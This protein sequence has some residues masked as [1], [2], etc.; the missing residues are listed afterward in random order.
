[1]T[2]KR[3]PA[4]FRGL[5]LMI[6]ILLLLLFAV[7]FLLAVYYRS[8]F[9]LNTWINGIYCTGKT[10]GQVNEE[11]IAQT[12]PPVV[13][14]STNS[15]RDGMYDNVID[16]GEMGYRCD[17]LSAL[18]DYMEKQNPYLWVDNITFHRDHRIEPEIS[19]DESALRAA[20]GRTC[21]QRYSEMRSGD[22]FLEITEKTGW[23]RYDGLTH[24]FDMEKA[25]E[26]VKAAIA[27]GRS[28]INIDELDC[29]YDIPFTDTQEQTRRMYEKLRAFLDCD[30]R[31]D[32]G[33]SFES[34]NEVQLSFFLQYSYREDLKMDYPVLDQNGQFVLKQEEV[35]A[36]VAGLAEKYDT[37]GKDREFQSTRGD[38]VTVPG[39]GTYGTTLDQH[40]E[41]EY[42][43]EH[44]LSG[45]LHDGRASDRIPEYQRQGA[46]RGKDDIGGTYI[47]VDMTRQHL[48]YY[49]DRELQFETDVVTGNTGRRMGTPEGVNYVY[50][51]QRNRTLRGP[52]YATPVKYWMPVKGNVGIHDAGWRTDFGGE[53]YKKNG[54]HG[55]INV[56]R[57]VMGELYDQV[58]IGTPVIM[59][60]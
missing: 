6:F 32:M 5:V 45:E 39:K 49:V 58:E 43:M 24:V 21:V 4:L 50:N 46:V 10:V 11:L 51:K 42:L 3:K 16:L 19:Y 48:Y 34:P 18:K 23:G 59:F 57:D 38:L 26:Q 37:Y 33:D 28:E 7:Y 36:Y 52:G 60:Y 30:F 44:L 47:E 29:F 55:C 17:Y 14:I 20:F 54:S 15:G 13:V 1:M 31:Y 56:P 9:S 22:Y 27:E 25:F 2:R 53:I 8:G 12:R 41:V 35:A 40:A